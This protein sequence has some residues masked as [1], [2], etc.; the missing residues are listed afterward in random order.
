MKKILSFLLISFCVVS[1]S[2]AQELHM[3]LRIK[4]AYV[5]GTRTADGMP[6]KNYWINSGRYDI[7]I[8]AHPPNRQ[9]NGKERIVYFNNSPDSLRSIV[10]KL[11]LNIHKP[12]S[13]R[14]RDVPEDYLTSGIHIDQF[15]INGKEQKWREPYGHSTWQEVRLEEPL[16]SKDS[17]QFDISWH[18]DL[19]LQSGR[20]GMIDSTTY[21]LA[22][23]YPRV[24][25]YDDYNGWDRMDFNDRQE[26]Y[27]DFNDYTFSV[28]VPKNYIVW[29]TGNLLNAE[30]VLQPAYAKKLKESF[31]SDNIFHIA[32]K[33]DLEKKNIT[34]QNETNTWKWK[35]DHITDIALCIS[36][37]YVWDA[38][39]V[40]VDSSTGRRASVQSAFNDTARD[41][42]HMV[43]F[44][45]DALNWFSHNLPGVPY[46]FPKT[47]IV[48]GYADMEY[49]M[50]VNDGSVETLEEARFV[51]EHELAH[52]WFPFYMG[53]NET[54]YGFMDEGWA[55]TFEYLI[56]I[57]DLG[58]EGATQAYKNFRVVRWQRDGTPDAV[59]PIITPA[60]AIT[61]AAS[62]YNQYVKPSLGYL[63]V[64][65]LLGDDVF[66]KCLL[67]YMK[68]WNG[69]HPIPWDFF[70]IFNTL[71][72]KDLN[73]FWN[74]WFFSQGKI[75]FAVG[76][77]DQKKNANQIVLKNIGGFPAPVDIHV[78]YADGSKETLHQ[79][80]AIWEKDLKTAVVSVPGVKKINSVQLDG[81]IFMDADP[82]DN[83]W[84]AK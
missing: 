23:F 32:N 38:S 66:K 43:S 54:R 70:N 67:G 24:A 33:S 8:V 59:I 29:S 77:V 16:R 63:A 74:S 31:S 26:F 64:K 13:L 27:N 5:K 28:T 47:T 21:Y 46:P 15:S 2:S 69:K 20:E 18:Y 83:T 62:S 76:S 14:A 34:A 81:G 12:G 73:W 42:H 35:A 1:Y 79:T 72:G 11:L 82:S 7:S 6:G 19:S 50:M 68:H 45:R 49:P 22:Y 65:D 41:F 4:Q 17:I 51:A 9:V 55:T 53:I 44:G 39:S 25:V 80:P 75:N 3:P 58:K 71:S 61:G 84:N 37:H 78:T 48:Q 57:H 52:T 36:D 56:G 10:F 40:V 60:D 30:E